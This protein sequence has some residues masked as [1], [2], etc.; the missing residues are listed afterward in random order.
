MIVHGE[1]REICREAS[2]QFW[3]LLVPS[4]HAIYIVVCTGVAEMKLLIQILA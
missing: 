3:L 1:N 2:V 4:P